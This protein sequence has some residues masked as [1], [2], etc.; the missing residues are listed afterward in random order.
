[1]SAFHNLVDEFL[2]GYL[3]LEI[4][5]E[6]RIVTKIY[7]PEKRHKLNFTDS[8]KRNICI[9]SYPTDTYFNYFDHY[10][11]NLKFYYGLFYGVC[12]WKMLKN[13]ASDLCLVYWL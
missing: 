11:N 3:D 5:P 13:G 7:T 6:L 4:H 8:R 1:M 12:L 9:Y 10:T 2:C